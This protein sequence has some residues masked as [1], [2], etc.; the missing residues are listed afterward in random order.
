MS[1]AKRVFTLAGLYGVVTLAPMLLLRDF[2]EARGGAMTYPEHFYGFVGTALA[3]Q[4]VFLVI[5]RD[6][7]RF[8]P[9]MLPSI[10]EKLAFG[11]PVWW[12]F[13]RGEVEAP[14]VAFA[15]V[16]LAL[17]VL[18]ALAWLRTRPAA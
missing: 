15:T 7:A 9:L 13:A 10:V 5:G 8:R 12:L 4:L 6:P 17:A 3:F 14:V 2:I 11:L 18:F 16:D 1:F